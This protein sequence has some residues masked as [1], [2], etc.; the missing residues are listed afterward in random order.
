MQAR[1]TEEIGE[2]AREL[3]H[4]HGTKKKKSSEDTKSLDKNYQMS[5]LLFV[6]SLIVIKLTINTKKQQPKIITIFKNSKFIFSL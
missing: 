6:V 4:I 3:N 1:L 5:H 2:V